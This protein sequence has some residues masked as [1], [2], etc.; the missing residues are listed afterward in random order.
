MGEGEGEGEREGGGGGLVVGAAFFPAVT[1]PASVNVSLLAQRP[2]HGTAVTYISPK[3]AVAATPDRTRACNHNYELGTLTIWPSA[4]TLVGTHR[5][6]W[7][8]SEERF[9]VSALIR[10]R[11]GTGCVL[12]VPSPS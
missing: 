10:S 3:G 9:A 6:R 1:C 4:A 2:V 12:R 11:Q 8:E 7:P 5:K